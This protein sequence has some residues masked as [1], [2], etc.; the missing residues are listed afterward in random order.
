MIA[1]AEAARSTPG[2][3]A[4]RWR[5]AWSVKALLA[6]FMAI[7]ADVL[8]F[9]PDIETGAALGVFA[10]VMLAALAISR[11]GMAISAMEIAAWTGGLLMAL[12]MVEDP[13]VLAFMLFWCA[14]VTIGLVRR[15]AVRG[16]GQWLR[17]VIAKSV[18]LW[19][20]PLADLTWLARARKRRDRKSIMPL[21]Q[22]LIVPALL[23]VSFIW[24]FSAANPLLDKLLASLNM[25]AVFE[26]LATD[27]VMLWLAASGTLYG[28]LRARWRA[29]RLHMVAA[30]VNGPPVTF[31]P[32]AASRSTASVQWLTTASVMWSLVVFNIMFALQNLSDI[33]FLWSGAALPEGTSF[34]DYAHRGAYPL[35]VTALLAAGFVLAA[36]RPGSA[37]DADR[38]V[39]L[40]VLA[41]IGQNAFLTL[42]AMLR[43]VDYVEAYSL[44]LLRLSALLWMALVGLGLLLVIVR[45]ARGK[46]NRWLID[47]NAMAALVLLG[48]CAAGNLSGAVAGYNVRHCREITGTGAALDIIYLREL[49]PAALP[50]LVWLQQ[51]PVDAEV[52]KA[53]AMHFAALIERLEA[54][55][56]DWRSWTFRGYRILPGAR[57]AELLISLHLLPNKEPEPYTSA[58]TP[59]P[60][61]ESA[62]P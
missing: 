62:R 44:T 23:G 1:A 52:K 30:A 28:L 39:R 42:S 27:R 46:T 40:L 3:P 26:G 49:G 57:D 5:A 13:S 21:L 34:A 24:L 48:A 59:P 10:L 12:A 25:A 56:S 36:L 60:A 29:R 33:A 15:K 45:V 43:T 9:H 32:V 17:A 50:A 16:A 7:A 47:T 53:A 35:I 4:P 61:A 14:I 22:L 6:V 20:A 54:Q 8:L 41:W 19:F 51:Q 58:A 37:T 11:P 18:L 55:Q 31:Q 38:R 2:R